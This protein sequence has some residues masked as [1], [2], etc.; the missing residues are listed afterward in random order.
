MSYPATGTCQ[1]ESVH[2][3]VRQAPLL[4]VV[5]HCRD[6]RKLSV[7]AFSMTMLIKR[8]NLE[9]VRGALGVF[10]RPAD[11]GNIARCYFCPSC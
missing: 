11:S 9:L 7:S 2:Y 10:D 5:S 8:E 4:T 6:C 3:I 1:C